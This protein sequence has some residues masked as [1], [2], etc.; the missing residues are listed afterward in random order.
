L[1][2]T[3]PLFFKFRVEKEKFQSETRVF[4]PETRSAYNIMSIR[5]ARNIPS[6]QEQYRGVWDVGNMKQRLAK[7]RERTEEDRKNAIDSIVRTICQ[8]ATSEVDFPDNFVRKWIHDTFSQS[9]N[10]GIRGGAIRQLETR[11]ASI[12]EEKK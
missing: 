7:A 6:V 9:E 5:N 4:N 11:E 12:A 2:S 3:W 8:F 1:P 10:V